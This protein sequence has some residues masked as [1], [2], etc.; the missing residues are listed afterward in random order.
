[1]RSSRL[2]KVPALAASLV[3]LAA[4]LSP[5]PAAA[6]AGPWA[7]AKEAK[8]RLLSR[9]AAA[10][11]GGDAGLGVEF[12]LAP[13]WHVY[14]KNA[15]DAGYAPALEPEGGALVA[16][17]L[18]YPV[19]S[20]FDLPGGLVAFG[21][22]HEVVYPLDGRLAPGAP[23][24]VQLAAQLDYL[25]CAES[26]IPYTVRLALELPLAAPGAEPA[27]DP[28]VAPLVDRGRDR[29]PA[30]APEGVRGRLL[31]G[32][33]E[34][35]TLELTFAVPGVRATTPDLFFEPHELLDLRRPEPIETAEGPG[36]RVPLRPLDETKPLPDRL[37]FAWTASGLELGG[38]PLAW[39]GV[40]DV[41]RPGPAPV[42]GVARYAAVALLASALIWFVLRRGRIHRAS[43]RQP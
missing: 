20:R 33:G 25:V 7:E 36:F 21:Y 5:R 23:S 6:V 42:S 26:C 4:A 12:Q 38:T 31:P 37:R 22:E 32:E 9:Y 2:F 30:A 16:P 11:P 15:G 43:P 34:A 24:P 17:Q 39:E 35:M 8:V 18:R 3:A 40:L 29:L 13:G 19:P 28:N 14:W 27:L 1:M 41:E 10:P